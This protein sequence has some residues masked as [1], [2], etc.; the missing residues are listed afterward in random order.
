M[1][2]LIVI[3]LLVAAAVVLLIGEALLPTHGLLGVLGGC[4]VVAVVVLIFRMN[5]WAGVGTFIV[6]VLL[7]PFLFGLF[8]K[9]WAKTPVG[10]AIILQTSESSPTTAPIQ[11]GDMGIAITEL[12][13]MGE[14]EFGQRRLEAISE[15]GIIPVGTR[16]KVVSL[17][18]DRTTVRAVES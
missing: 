8:V 16:V 15:L 13:P 2:P 10:R 7:S 6:L 5:R 9:V 12:R 17:S 1:D 18:K 14:C 3:L 4:C 11:L